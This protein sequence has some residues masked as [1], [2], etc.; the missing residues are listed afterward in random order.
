[1]H[2]G[3][4]MMIAPAFLSCFTTPA[5]SAGILFLKTPLAAVVLMPAVSILSFSATGM[6]CKG[7]F[8]LLR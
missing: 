6:P 7:P 5:S 3:F 4:A 8:H 1:M 2:I